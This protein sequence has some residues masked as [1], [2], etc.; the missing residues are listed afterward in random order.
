MSGEIELPKTNALAHKL[1]AMGYSKLGR[2]KVRKKMR[3]VWY[4]PGKISKAN[5]EIAMKQGGVDDYDP[6]VPF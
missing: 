1:V 6:D 3:T 2:I 5:A 4:K